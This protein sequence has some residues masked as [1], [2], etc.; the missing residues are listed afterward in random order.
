MRKSDVDEYYVPDSRFDRENIRCCEELARAIKDG[1]DCE[2][3]KE[4]SH[5]ESDVNFG[6]GDI[7]LMTYGIGIDLGTR[8]VCNDR[9]VHKRH[10]S[11]VRSIFDGIGMRKK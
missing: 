11:K 6:S 10:L 7:H 3:G 1:L 4:G 5:W 8:M 2:W 9:G